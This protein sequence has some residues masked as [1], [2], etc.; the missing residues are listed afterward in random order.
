MRPE[1][2]HTARWIGRIGDREGFRGEPLGSNGN[3]VELGDNDKR[4][5]PARGWYHFRIPY[6]LIKYKITTNEKER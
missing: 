4:S 5:P 3:K 1:A 6:T 2:I